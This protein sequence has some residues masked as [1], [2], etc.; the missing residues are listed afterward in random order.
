MGIPP[1]TVRDTARRHVNGSAANG[2]APATTSLT[3]RGDYGL[4]ETPESLPVLQA[5]HEFIESER[6]AARSKLVTLSLFFIAVVISLIAGAMAI[7]NTFFDQVEGDVRMVQAE[8]EQARR[9]LAGVK[10]DTQTALAGLSERT[11]IL[12]SD[13]LKDREALAAAH[14]QTTSLVSRLGQMN[15]VIAMLELENT[16]L[17]QDLG[18]MNSHLPQ[19]S[20]NLSVAVA[21][22]NRL[23]ELVTESTGRRPVPRRKGK[24]T[25]IVASLLLPGSETGTAWRFPIPE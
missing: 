1:K 6:K 12:R 16:S 17:R 14:A 15:E 25:T 24:S 8:S 19:V 9:Q 3:R 4:A 2:T 7:S 20:S 18:A 22:I 11:D 5:F 23:R 10:R 21:E 13:I